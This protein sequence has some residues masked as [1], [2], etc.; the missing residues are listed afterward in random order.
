MRSIAG[1]IS[2]EGSTATLVNSPLGMAGTGGDI[3][4]TLL[5]VV[6]SLALYDRSVVGVG[7]DGLDR[8][9]DGGLL[10][11][12]G[13]RMV[14]INSLV[15]RSGVLDSPLLAS[16]G[17]E[18]ARVGWLDPLNKRVKGMSKGCRGYNR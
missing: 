4:S 2:G 17:S 13:R 1:T 6:G 8:S 5:S 16:V 14:D 10:A 3:S 15:C 9:V 7:W 11:F 18:R 12:Q